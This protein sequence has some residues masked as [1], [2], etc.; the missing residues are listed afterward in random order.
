MILAVAISDHQRRI[1]LT[2]EDVGGNIMTSHSAFLD[3]LSAAEKSDLDKRLS[4]RQSGK[5]F[6]CDSSIDLVVTKANSKS[7][8]S[9]H[10]PRVARTRRTILHSCIAIV[11]GKKALRICG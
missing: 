3:E 1:L 11:I 2:H 9:N 5:C 7:I 10:S 4:D 6:V 8:I